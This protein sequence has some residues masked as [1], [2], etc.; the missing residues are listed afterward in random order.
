LFVQG[1][2]AILRSKS[3]AAVGTRKPSDDGI[4][5]AKYTAA[6]LQ[7]LKCSVVSGLAVGIDQ[8][9]HREALRYKQPTIAVLGHG[10]FAAYH[11]IDVKL[12]D[13]IVSSGGAIVSEY[14]PRQGPSAENFVRR[15]RLQSGLACALIPVEWNAKSGTAHTVR[16]S[17]E[18]DRALAALRLP[19]WGQR[20]ELTFAEANGGTVFTVP[21]E[22]EKL[23]RFLENALSGVAPWRPQ[24]SLPLR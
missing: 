8:L 12:R 20:D 23:Q 6:I 21:G 14:L 17:I 16:F 5:L 1:N 9:I 13:Q 4:F 22:D 7:Y 15:N 11:A 19:D 2:P 3:I 10:L 24:L 18:Q